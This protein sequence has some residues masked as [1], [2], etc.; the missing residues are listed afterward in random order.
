MSQP[1]QVQ[2]YFL[3]LSFAYLTQS[4]IYGRS[5]RSEIL[6]SLALLRTISLRVG[7]PS[8][9][10]CR[11]CQPSLWP[12]PTSINCTNGKSTVRSSQPKMMYRRYDDGGGGCVS[13]WRATNVETYSGTEFSG[14]TP[15]ACNNTCY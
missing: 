5:V 4:R 11:H 12:K 1:E 14:L 3:S 10:G 9:A 6:P 15:T 13:G 2:S 8:L 7:P